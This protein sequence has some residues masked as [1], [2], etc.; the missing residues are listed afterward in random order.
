VWWWL[1]CGVKSENWLF[2]Y[3]PWQLCRKNMRWA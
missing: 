1:V 3:L 2:W